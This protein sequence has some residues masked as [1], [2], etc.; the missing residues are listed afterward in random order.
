[1]A[2]R[3]Q[4]DEPRNDAEAVFDRLIGDT[5]GMGRAPGRSD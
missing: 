2:S 3:K 1:M 4:I 5:G